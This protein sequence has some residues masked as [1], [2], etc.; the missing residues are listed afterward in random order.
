MPHSAV[1]QQT[2][3]LLQTRPCPPPESAGAQALI[4]HVAQ[5]FQVSRSAAHVRLKQLAL[6]GPGST[7]TLL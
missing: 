2:A 5:T 4:E 3:M 6:I 7:P 1:R